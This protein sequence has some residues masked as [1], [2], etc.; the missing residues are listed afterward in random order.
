MCWCAVKNLLARSLTDEYDDIDKLT[1]PKICGY[2]TSSLT[3]A[4]DVMCRPKDDSSVDISDHEEEFYYTEVEENVDAVTQ[5]FADMQTMSPIRTTFAQQNDTM[6]LPDHD[7]QRKVNCLFY[8]LLTPPS[9]Q[10]L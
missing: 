10:W 7:Y 4:G 1:K 8:K 2:A 6:A 3:K 9:G 5:T